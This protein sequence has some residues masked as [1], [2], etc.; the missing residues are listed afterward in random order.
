MTAMSD[1]ANTLQD[2][3]S[4]DDPLQVIN[5]MEEALRLQNGSSA[6]IV[7]EAHNLEA[8]TDSYQ[9][10]VTAYT[11]SFA[12]A[13]DDAMQAFQ[14]ETEKWQAYTAQFKTP[15]QGAQSAA[16]AKKA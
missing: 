16:P 12:A 2:A 14:A 9:T 1:T 13:W 6:A 11:E 4:C 15:D 3:D 8:L 5:L 10:Y 7:E